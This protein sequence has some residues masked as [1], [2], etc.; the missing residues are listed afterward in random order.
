M[1]S[2]RKISV[3]SGIV[4]CSVLI[5]GIATATIAFINPAPEVESEQS[6]TLKILTTF[7]A[8]HTGGDFVNGHEGFA[9]LE[10]HKPGAGTTRQQI[11]ALTK[12]ALFDANYQVDFGF[13]KVSSKQCLTCHQRNDDRHPIYRF[14]EPRFIKIVEQLPANQCLGCHS[15]HNNK[16][17]NLNEIGFCVACHSELI[18][19]NDPLDVSHVK[20]IKTDDWDSCLGCHDFHGNHKFTPPKVYQQA[21]SAQRIKDYFAGDASPY[22]TIKKTVRM[23]K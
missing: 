10:C 5:L 17:V 8:I 16:T 22:G 1:N 23:Q 12:N 7:S 13:K 6:N 4:F 2:F 19:K 15:E 18:L 21:I 20:L 3:L 11:Q 14:N 9:C